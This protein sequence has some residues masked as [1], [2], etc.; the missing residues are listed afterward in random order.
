MSATQFEL[1][2]TKTLLIRMAELNEALL[3]TAAVQVI[4]LRGCTVSEAVA[5]VRRINEE[6]VRQK[7]MGRV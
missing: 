3:T 4:V 7:R 5:E 6:V 1:D 2:S